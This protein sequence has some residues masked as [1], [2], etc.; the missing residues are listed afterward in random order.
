MIRPVRVALR[1]PAC[2]AWW[3]QVTVVPL[4]SRMTVFSSGR[5]QASS[6]STPLGGQV[7]QAAAVSAQ[8][9]TSGMAARASLKTAISKNIQKKAAKNI[10]SEAMNMI[11]P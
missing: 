7:D 3:A 11:M 2:I 8:L 9:P 10:T 4:S 5:C 6:V 1:S